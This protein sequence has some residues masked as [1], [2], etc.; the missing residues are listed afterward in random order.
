LLRSGRP[1]THAQRGLW[2]S[3]QQN[4]TSPLQNMAEVAHITGAIDAHRLADAFATVVAASDVLRTRVTVEAGEPRVVVDPP[5]QRAVTEILPIS[6]ADVEAWCYAR[7]RVPIDTGICGYDSVLLTHDDHS[8]TWYLGLH[9][10]ITDATSSALVFN[11]TADAYAGSEVELDSYYRWADHRM[12]AGTNDRRT[13]RARAH[14]RDRPTA[15]SLGQLYAGDHPSTPVSHR[16]PVDVSSEVFDSLAE[17][18][19][20]DLRLLSTDLGWSTLLLT[21]TSALLHRVGGLADFAVGLPVHHRNDVA[22]REVLGPVM[23]VY[24]VDVHV[25][26]DDTFRSLYSRIARSVIRTLQHAAPVPPPPNPDYRVVMNLL[27]E[28]EQQ[29]F[30]GCPAE[31]SW[32]H[33]GATDPGHLMR[34]QFTRFGSEPEL[35]LDL[36]EAAA[37][38]EQ[39]SRATSHMRRLLTALAA[40][41]DQTIGSVVLPEAAELSSLD[42]WARGDS[43]SADP[44][45]V[46][47]RLESALEGLDHEVLNHDGKCLV[48]DDLWRRVVAYARW[49]RSQGVGKGTRVAIDLPRS[50]DAVVAIY[51]TL[52]AGASYVPLDPAHPTERRRRLVERAGCMLTLDELPAIDTSGQPL[53][54][55]P[56]PTGD[57]E[58]YLLFTSGST[59]EPKGV[60]ILHRGLADYLAFA[61]DRYI[62]KSEDRPVGALFTALTFDLTVTSLFGPIVAGG[63]LVVIQPDGPAGLRKLADRD[64][65]TWVKATP[66]HLELFVRLLDPSSTHGL[67]TLVVGGEAFGSRLAQKLWAALPDVDVFNEYGPTEAVVGC[68]IHRATPASVAGRSDVPIGGPAPGVEL[69]I[70]DSYDQ[71]TPMGAAGELHIAH[72]GVTSGYL[73][74]DDR[75]DQPF[76]EIEGTRF[77]RSGDLVRLRDDGTLSYLGRLDEQLKV[78]GIRLDP[79]EVEHALVA[80]PAVQRAVVRLWQPTGSNPTM[81]CVR[82]GLPDNVPGSSFDD[83]GVCSTCHSYEAIRHQADAWFRGQDDLLALKTKARADRTGRYDAVHLLSGGKDSTFALY[84][85]VELGFDVLCLTLDNGFISD[86]AIANVKRSAADLGVDFELLTSDTMNEVFRDSLDRFSNVCHGCYKTIYTLATQRAVEVGAPMIV[87]GLSRGQLFETRLIPEQFS[88]G[89][90][91]PDAIDAATLEAR[92][93]YHRLDDGTN[94]LLDTTVFGPDVYETGDVFDRVAY[95]DF[96]R[97]IDVELAEMFDFLDNRAPWIRPSDTG[98]STNCLVNAAGIHTHIT[99]Q[100]FHNYAEPYAWDVRLGHKT[101]HEAMDELAD[102]LDLDDVSNMLSVIGYE[103]APRSLLTAWLETSGDESLDVNELRTLLAE[104]LPSHAVPAAVVFVDEIPLSLNGKVDASRLPAPKRVHRAGP[105]LY[106]SA[107]SPLEAS[108]VSVWERLL[109]VEPIGVDDDFFALGGDSLAALKMVVGLSAELGT[110]IREEVAFINS[111]PRT[112]AEAVAPSLAGASVGQGVAVAADPPEPTRRGQ[113]ERPPLS[114]GEEAILFEHYS[115]ADNPRYNVARRYRVDGSVDADRF[116]DAVQVVMLRHVPLHWTFSEPR[117]KLSVR[118]ALSVSVRLGPISFDQFACDSSALHT[119]AFDLDDGPLGRCLVQALEGGA[120]GITLVFHHASIDAGTFDDLWEQVDHVYRGGSLADLL[121]AE[122]QAIDYADHTSWQRSRDERLASD[123]E[124]WSDA[125]RAG[126]A[127]LLNFGGSANEPDGYVEQPASF[128]L[129]RLRAGAGTTPFATA[130]TA[131]A[132]TLRQHADGDRLALSITASTRDHATAENL[133]GYYLNTLP[134]LATVDANASLAQLGSHCSALIAGA[135]GHRTYPF[136]NM[137]RDRRRLDLPPPS[138]SM[139]LAFEELA[140][141]RLGTLVAEHA[142]LASGS[143]VTDATFFVQGRGNDVTLG[144]EY[145]GALL[146]RDDAIALLGQFDHF[147]L[148]AIERPEDRVS[149]AQLMPELDSWNDTAQPYSSD[150]AVNDAFERHAAATPDALAVVCGETT[151]TYG[152]LE[153]RANVLAH[154]LIDRGVEPGDRVGVDARR[155]PDTVVRA[156]AVLKAGAVYVP[157]DPD[158]PPARIAQI[159]EDAQ[160]RLVL[161]P[162]DGL[163]AEAVAVESDP[164]PP[165]IVRDDQSLAYVLFTSGS[166]GRP[167]GVM[168][169]HRNIIESTAARQ[170]VYVEPARRFLL[171]SSFAFDSSM[172]GLFWSLSEGGMLVL[173]EVGRHTDPPYLAD[174]VERQQVT[175]LLALPALYRLLLDDSEADQLASLTTAIVAGE[176]CPSTLAAAHTDRCPNAS[177]WNE[178]GPTEAT[179]WSHAYRVVPSSASDEDHGALPVPIGKPI[180][181]MIANV[182][183]VDQSAVPI[184]EPGELYLGG[185]GVAQGYLKQP[186]RTRQS[187]VRLPDPLDDGTLHYRTGDLVRW[188]PSGDLEFLGRVD[189]QVKVRGYR[190][191]LGELEAIAEA[192]ELVSEAVAA[193]IETPAGG[194]QL[195][196]WVGVRAGAGGSATVADRAADLVSLRKQLARDLPA[197][198]VPAHV[199]LIDRLPR[200]PNGKIDREALPDPR[201]V[202][203]SSDAEELAPQE[204]IEQTVAAIWEEVLGVEA[205]GLADDFFELGGDSIM[206]IQIVSRLRRAG[207]QLSTRDVFEYPTVAE[208]AMRVEPLSSIGVHADPTDADSTHPEAADQVVASGVVPLLPIQRWF[209]AQGLTQ[210]NHWNQ[211]RWLEVAPTIDLEKLLGAVQCLSAQHDA[212]RLRLR[213]PTEPLLVPQEPVAVLV[214]DAPIHTEFHTGVVDTDQRRILASAAESTLDLVDGPVMAAVGF[215]AAEGQPA[216]VFVTV[217]HLVIDAVSWVPLLEDWTEFHQARA[218]PQKTTSVRQW[219]ESLGPWGSSPVA[220]AERSQWQQLAAGLTVDRGRSMVEA[221]TNFVTV[222]VGSDVVQSAAEQRIVAALGH[223]LGVVVSEPSPTLMVEGHGR[224][225]EIAPGSDLSRTVGWFTTHRP[226]KVA[227][228]DDAGRTFQSLL[229]VTPAAA[230]GLAY[231]LTVDP[232]SG[233]IPVLVN[234]LGR[235]DRATGATDVFTSVGPLAA[236]IAADNQRLHRL[237]VMASVSNDTLTLVFDHHPEQVPTDVVVDLAD[238]TIAALRF[239]AASDGPAPAAGSDTAT[240]DL[241]DLSAEE[242]SS[243]GDVLDALDD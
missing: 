33:P 236:G 67:R 144:L 109:G 127:S 122:T 178:Y 1:L 227:V 148:A 66:S 39:H 30:A 216:Q 226:V 172:V 188:L 75:S 126:T 195:A 194:K 198:M 189:H 23:Q 129:D 28:T 85:L 133:V 125:E 65:I 97:Y 199:V 40:D 80:H 139:L 81:H 180:P 62:P 79:T 143:A 9:H 96:Y 20:D 64:D 31:V 18:L 59:G 217:H 223:A 196:L 213:P 243:L 242:L 70:L 14:W 91:D 124:Y 61:L 29:F 58:A 224:Q 211:S 110:T 181:N 202:V 71:P 210:P 218:L 41:P 187:F 234:Y 132:A 116:I 165:S 155:G 197:F 186:E 43:I 241:V 233:D 220:E 208:L 221:D 112:L 184:G 231:G 240:F 16:V 69:R 111:T 22:S 232:A 5:S 102:H 86:G 88:E 13:D 121:G 182:L 177:L 235:I 175:H 6:R 225:S 105:S 101:R 154:L 228:G 138:A 38:P 2:I 89:R 168:V 136:A 161:S 164:G 214:D 120:T 90:F 87:T 142:V 159:T 239:I 12:D 45:L 150:V 17:R 46:C 191:E 146:K 63:R 95:V 104:R 34:V 51:A 113:S 179:V 151:L 8:I 99:E 115:D 42:D 222:E 36:N 171:L 183:S 114:S 238:S 157:I 149:A 229:E 92:R 48:A 74:T 3:Q 119:Q 26:A 205:I 55:W 173:P 162:E 7:V 201:R 82:C 93:A 106:V 4:P 156:L 141:A 19:R 167:K 107:Q 73:D 57:D 77:Y 56:L 11:K 176:A 193:A 128:T 47:P 147:L 153:R 117:R 158:Y 108:I 49:L 140:N 68:M 163:L 32:I 103:P 72:R 203:A 209:L 204:G 190:V 15:P 170:R 118:E 212:L 137:V 44:P 192:S 10:I 98:R 78:G 237:G 50:N 230:K 52:L 134:L 207:W 219:A 169:S 215:A 25:A 185:I 35:F 166:T 54:D 27:P 131:L 37:S 84:K 21:A 174:L 135:L 94:R 100:G 60:P 130:F 76:V 160:T 152:Q 200:T 53:I 145:S 83:D 123:A 24:P 206:S